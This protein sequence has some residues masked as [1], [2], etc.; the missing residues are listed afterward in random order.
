MAVC[1]VLIDEPRPGL[2]NM[3]IDEMLLDRAAAEGRSHL[4][5]YGWSEPTLS[6]GYFQR[7]AQRELHR[8]SIECPLVRRPSGGG[9]IVHDHEV[10]YALAAPLRGDDLST[11][12]L[13]GHLHAAFSKL[14]L[15]LGAATTLCEAPAVPASG[16]GHSFLCFHRPTV[17]DVLLGD[18]KVVG[19]A[20]RRARGALLQHGSILLRASSA[21]P[22]LPGL[23][24]L[25]TIAITPD[26]W[27]GLLR[28]AILST[29]ESQPVEEALSDREHDQAAALVERKFG[30][31]EWN[32]RR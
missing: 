5:F 30:R 21:A 4:R 29:I 1:R 17:G 31:R 23:E 18:F 14:F 6:L 7:M 10:T 3:A 16:A 20:Q 15:K 2:W 13:C 32:Q 28:D 26:E 12:G 11:R 25:S 24:D 8:P 19:S 22:E 27:R 9:A